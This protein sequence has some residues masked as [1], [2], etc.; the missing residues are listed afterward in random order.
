MVL[1][2]VSFSFVFAVSSAT[3][4]P[5]VTLTVNTTADGPDVNPGDGLCEANVGV[6]DCTLRAAIEE[7]NANTNPTDTDVINFAIPGAGIHTIAPL[8]QLPDIT[9]P[10]SVDGSSQ[11]GVDCVNHETSIALDGSSSLLVV[12]K[13][14][15]GSDGSSVNGLSFTNTIF[16]GVEVD[17]I[18]GFEVTCSNFGVSADGI[19]PGSSGGYGLNFENVNNISI[20][21]ASVSD[22][23]LIENNGT[24]I[25]IFG[26]SSNIDIENNIIKKSTMLSG[27]EIGNGGT[28][29]NVLITNNEAS[30]TNA[31]NAWGA[32]ITVDNV[33]GIVVTNNITN[34]NNGSTT[35]LGVQILNS[36]DV[37]FEN[38]E[39]N[40]NGPP[41]SGGSR[42]FACYTCEDVVML[43]NVLNNNGGEGS[44]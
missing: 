29:S 6:G 25:S 4:A 26:N 34:N 3:A 2:L 27:I 13:F 40:E 23:N 43:N 1:T 9:E 35:G 37:R 5:G 19:T 39:S 21:G 38:N 31:S 41:L 11:G 32:G 22:G 17:D 8:S 36:K 18:D 30:D 24:G 7:T 10:L 42:G 28:F 16:Q 20:G 44:G 14:N 33:D 15:V 12:L